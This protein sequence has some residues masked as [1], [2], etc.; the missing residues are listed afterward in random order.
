MS[1]FDFTEYTKCKLC[2]RNCGVDRS[3]EASGFCHANDRLA[4]GSICR[5]T[6][7]EPPISGQYGIANIFFMHCTLQCQFCQNMQISQ[8]KMV[9][10]PY[11]YRVHEVTA[12][13]MKLLEEGCKAVGFV[14][15][16][17]YIPHVKAIISELKSNGY[18]PPFVYNTSGY[19]NTEQLKE[20]EEWVDVWLPDF[21]YADRSLARRLSMASNYP[22]VA[23]KA[24]R[25]MFRQKGSNVIVN[26]EG[27]A[28]SGL[29]IRHLVLPGY[30]ENSI[31]VLE[32]IADEISTN[33][34]ISLMSQYNPQFYQKMDVALQRPIDLQ[35]YEMVVQRFYELG[36]HNGWIQEL[37]SHKTY[38]PDFEQE[39]P[40]EMS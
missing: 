38:N 20:L 31:K 4:I 22:E 24:I 7:E 28:E 27:Q 40:F 26:K 37:E 23:L 29:I 36:F 11:L 25:E 14:S 8:N 39:H 32:T 6:G 13:V 19:E 17:H 5:H 21:K 9:L 16:T 1:E 34:Y 18:H 2:P 15:P 30:I 10:D 35:E 3:K 33:V 12:R